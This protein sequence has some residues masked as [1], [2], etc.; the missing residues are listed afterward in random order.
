MSSLDVERAVLERYAAGARRREEAL[1]C[2]STDYDKARLEIV[3]AEIVERDYGCGDPSRYLR[4]GQTVVDLGSGAGKVCYIAAQVVGPAGRVVGVD[5]NP[6]MLALARRHRKAVGDRLGYHNVEFRRAKIQDLAL[7]LDLVDEYLKAR[8]VR[9]AEDWQAFEEH[10]RR[11]R[12]ERPMIADGSAD[13]VVS[14]CVLNLVRPQDKR[15]LF[16][17]MMRVLRP[18]GYAAISDIVCDRPV[19]PDL[20]QDPALWSGCLAGAFQEQEFYRAFLAAGF[21]PL[22]IATRDDAARQ[23]VNGIEFRSVT[24][25]ARKPPAEVEH[26][27]HEQFQVV[28]RGPWAEVKCD[29]RRVYHRGVPTTVDDRTYRMLTAEPFTGQFLDVERA[30]AAQPAGQAGSCCGPGACG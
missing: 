10:C 29:D 5:F 2:P 28:Y 1:C 22:E 30:G 15:A 20:Q 23:L 25:I 19:P 9:S 26:T 24:V 14:N 21:A 13:A 8:P 3:P 27:A 11:L 17:E 16:T 18:G 4:A 7:D 6:E 12:A